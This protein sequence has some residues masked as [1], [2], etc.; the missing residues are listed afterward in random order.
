V[1]ILSSVKHSIHKTSSFLYLK[2]PTVTFCKDWEAYYWAP[3]GECFEQ[4]SR[5]PC[6]EGQYFSFNLTSRQGLHEI[7]LNM[8][9][10]GGQCTVVFTLVVTE[11]ASGAGTGGGYK[12]MSSIF[13]D[14]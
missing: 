13:A 5:G 12:K 7:G 1:R 3:L 2:P 11:P 10:S 9:E 4:E 6:Q 8:K 14:Q